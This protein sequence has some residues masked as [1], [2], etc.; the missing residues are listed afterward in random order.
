MED[1]TRIPP[2]SV[3]SEQSILGS[4][5]CRFISTI[6]IFLP[7]NRRLLGLIESML[8]PLFLILITF[9]I[10]HNK[11]NCQTKCNTF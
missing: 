8:Y 2:H 7:S 4:I 11:M 5:L 6:F 9:F 1:I 3:E 10:L